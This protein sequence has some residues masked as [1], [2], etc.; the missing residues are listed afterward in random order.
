MPVTYA[1]STYAE[2]RDNV[3]ADIHRDAELARL[4][5]EDFISW[6]LKA[7]ERIC[8]LANIEESYRLHYAA[9]V[10]EYP[11]QDRPPITGV[12][13]SGS[14]IVISSAGHGLAVNDNIFTRDVQ[15]AIAAN[16]RFRVSSVP[17]VNTF[18]V[19]RFGRISGVSADTPPVITSVDHPFNTGDSVTISGVVGAT[20]VNGTWTATKIDKDSFSID[21]GSPERHAYESGGIAVADSTNS[22]AYI[23]GGRYWKEDEVP[24]HVAVLRDSTVNYN[25]CTVEVTAVTETDL[26]RE[27]VGEVIITWPYPRRIALENKNG[28]RFLHL[29]Y[30]PTDVGDLDIFHRIQVTP[31]NFRGDAITTSILLSSEHDS[32]IEE[33]VKSKV[34]GSVLKD[35]NAAVFHQQN[36]ERFVAGFNVRQPEPRRKVVYD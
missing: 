10:S 33:Y 4:S 32:A 8:Q 36:F 23:G 19:K 26:E 28:Q 27:Q 13:S 3:L 1:R 5:A 20:E 2:I 12:S 34:F 9:K 31:K 6:I 30:Q 16:G 29:Q 25:G 24:T 35:V 21:I 14:P 11:L 15:G 17:D 22:V 18:H 7:Q